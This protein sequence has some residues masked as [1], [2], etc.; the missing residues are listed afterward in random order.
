MA[1]SSWIGKSL[2]NRYAIESLLGQGGMSAVFKAEDP[3]LRRTVAVKLIHP[4][5]SGD[6]QFVSRFRKRGFVRRAAA[7]PQHHPGFR[8]RP[9]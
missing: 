4:H 8:F 6:P 7:A 2:G 1:R 3:N 5:L 9:R